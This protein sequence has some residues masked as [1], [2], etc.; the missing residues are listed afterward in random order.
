L[1]EPRLCVSGGVFLNCVA[2]H[3]ILKA[4]LFTEFYAMPA[5]GDEGHAVGAAF[6][7]SALLK[8]RI[9]KSV[10]L[11]ADASIPH[12]LPYPGLSYDRF[13][14]EA[15]IDRHG[16]PHQWHDDD[17]LADEIASL[18]A[19]GL[20]V[21][22]LRGRSELGPRALGH[23]S[24][25]ADPRLPSMKDHLNA[26]VKFR[27]AFRPY[28]PMVLAEHA[29][30]IFDLVQPS[31]FML[32][33]CD[34]RAQYQTLLP[35]I[36]HVDGTARVQTVDSQEPFLHALLTAFHQRTGLAVLLNT[37]FNLAGEPIVETPEDAVR[38]FLSCGLDVLVLEGALI[39]KARPADFS[40]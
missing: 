5:C 3:K 40:T 16:L 19:Q 28:A 11:P 32:F 9:P 29:T 39:T 38:A 31:P 20:T 1:N 36:T 35:A 22:L 7:A 30:E 8:G 10:P 18:I 33:A 34:V 2:N 6:A 27:E 13:A 26:N 12:V 23:R 4:G 25:L 37:S 14:V 24:I 15:V 21:G 17:V